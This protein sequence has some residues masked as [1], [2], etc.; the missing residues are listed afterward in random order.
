MGLD[1]LETGIDKTRL[2]WIV[3]Y[4]CIWTSLNWINMEWIELDL[5][6]L[7]LRINWTGSSLK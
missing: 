5:F 7:H 6:G 3:D 1:C 4:G 2:K